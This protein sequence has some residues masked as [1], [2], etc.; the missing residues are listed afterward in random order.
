MRNKENTRDRLSI[1]LLA[2][3][4]NYL[5]RQASKRGV[6]TQYAESSSCNAASGEQ[7][8]EHDENNSGRILRHFAVERET[9]GKKERKREEG[10]RKQCEWK[11]STHEEARREERDL[12]R[13]RDLYI[14]TDARIRCSD[15]LI[16]G[17][18][19]RNP[20]RIFRDI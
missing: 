11:G 6:S 1:A 18:I 4:S 2:C 8:G 3:R 14:S 16:F 13:T 19:P 10:E 15:L 12:E 17:N 9:D 5:I 20:L 7:S